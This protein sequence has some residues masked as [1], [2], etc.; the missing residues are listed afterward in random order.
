MAGIE[1]AF[2]D[3]FEKLKGP[4]YWFAGVKNDIAAGV[5]PTFELESTGTIRTPSATQ[6]PNGFALGCTQDGWKVNSEFSL[7]NEFCDESA[8]P[9]FSAIDTQTTTLEANLRNPLNEAVL[10][11][12]WGLIKVVNGGFDIFSG[13]DLTTLLETALIGVFKNPKDATKLGYLYYPKASLVTAFNLDAISRKKASTSLVRFSILSNLAR[14][15]GKEV[16]DLGKE[17]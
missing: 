17:I 4:I 14:G 2:P 16:F 1:L 10:T 13:G 11:K 7:S 8:T 12:L 3:N 6:S 15:A 9:E 5:A